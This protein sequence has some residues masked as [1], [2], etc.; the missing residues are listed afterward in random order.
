MSNGGYT[1][2]FLETSEHRDY[3]HNRFVCSG[4]V[5]RAEIE[6]LSLRHFHSDGLSSTAVFA[7]MPSASVS[8]A[9]AVNPGLLR[10]CRNA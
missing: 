9:T 1:K 6:S 2:M 5:I 7:P 8:T 4:W 3:H 10:S